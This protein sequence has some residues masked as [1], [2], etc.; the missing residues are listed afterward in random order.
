MA[1]LTLP[2]YRAKFMIVGA[3]LVIEDKEESDYI[4]VRA[5]APVSNKSMKCIMV[6]KGTSGLLPAVE[7]LLRQMETRH[8]QTDE[9]KRLE[10]LSYE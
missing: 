6:R 7:D 10:E 8:I 9:E 2:E 3:K 5:I 1:Y 4:R